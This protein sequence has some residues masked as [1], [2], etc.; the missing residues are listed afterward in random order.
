MSS[1]SR[2]RQ[3]GPPLP[4]PAVVATALTVAAVVVYVGSPTPAT[5]PMAALHY[6]RLHGTQQ[7][8]LA[9]L[10]A[11]TSIPLATWTAAT[12]RRLRTLGVTAPG[13]AI[14]LVGGT[15]ASAS[16][17][18]SGLVTWVTAESAPSVDAGTARVLVDLA[19]VTGAAG[20]TMPF[21]LLLAGVAVP[22]LLLGLLPRPL[23]WAG[24]VLAA[25]G[26]LSSLT[27][28]TSMLDATLPIT[29]FGGL[30]WAIA[31]GVA[32]PVTRHRNAERRP[33]AATAHAATVV[34]W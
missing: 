7:R 13:A 28:L 4:L 30:V 5:T 29:R 14:A 33:G 18:L 17:A 12:Y 23:A 19:F 9:F 22:G 3:G 8:A 25:V 1:P 32:L 6:L 10:V 16:L 31:A 11:S 26:V 24:L 27:L 21:G 34:K 2:R 20:F 15:L